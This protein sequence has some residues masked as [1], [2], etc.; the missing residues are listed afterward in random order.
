[1]VHHLLNGPVYAL[2]QMI[3]FRSW[4]MIV[5]QANL[6]ALFVSLFFFFLEKNHYNENNNNISL[7]LIPHWLLS[8]RQFTYLYIFEQVTVV[9]HGPT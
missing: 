8:H 7:I 2:R 6:I 4:L 5:C 3:V 9:A 1:M